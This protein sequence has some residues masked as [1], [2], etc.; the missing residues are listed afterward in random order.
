MPL[1]RKK[2]PDGLSDKFYQIDNDRNHK[3]STQTLK[4][5]IEEETFLSHFIAQNTLKPKPDKGIIQKGN[6]K[7]KCKKFLN[8]ILANKS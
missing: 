7:Y 1:T 5:F 3:N 4:I 8:K 6:H 2:M